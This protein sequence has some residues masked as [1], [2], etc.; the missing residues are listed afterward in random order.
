MAASTNE[1]VFI[2]NELRGLMPHSPDAKF[3]GTG[4]LESSDY[5]LVNQGDTC[6]LTAGRAAGP[7]VT[8]DLYRITCPNILNMIRRAHEIAQDNTER[9]GKDHALVAKK[10]VVK[11]DKGAYHAIVYYRAD[12]VRLV[13]LPIISEWRDSMARQSAFEDALECMGCGNL[14]DP[15]EATDIDGEAHCLNCAGDFMGTEGET[16][17]DEGESEGDMSFTLGENKIYITTDY[18]ETYGPFDSVLD[19]IGSIEDM[20]TELTDVRTLTVGFRLVRDGLNQ[21]AQD[22]VEAGTIPF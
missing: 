9:G 3:I 6:I 15:M 1:Y 5:V 16:V 2:Y 17:D 7:T 20:V 18:G 4:R 14:M 13:G 8:G 12:V 19:A 21:D 22:E 10:M 11:V